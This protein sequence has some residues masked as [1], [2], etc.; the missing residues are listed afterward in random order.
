MSNACVCLYCD[1]PDEHFWI[2]RHP[3]MP[4]LT[5]AAG[6]SGH[7]FKFA[8]VL[9]HLI[10]DAAEGYPSPVG[11]RFAWRSFTAGAVG[12]EASRAR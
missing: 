4:G 11:D 7:A 5:V 8:P 12:Q 2:D 10:A 9:G 6:D 3:D 1:T